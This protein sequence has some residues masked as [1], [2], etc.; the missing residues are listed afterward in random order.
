IIDVRR[1]GEFAAEHVEGAKS[2]PLDFINEDMAQFPKDAPFIIHCQGGYR[3]MI[4][5]SILKSRGY[6]N[7]IEVVGGYGAIAKTGVPKT[8]YVCPSTLRK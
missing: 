8:D 3:S 1:P 4:A 5:A 7:F 6:D 2:I